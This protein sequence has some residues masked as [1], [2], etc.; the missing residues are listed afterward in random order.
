M[1]YLPTIQLTSQVSMLLSKGALHLQPGQWVAGEKGIG[2]YL[3]TDHRTG[4]TYVSWVRPG[5][6][7]TTQSQRFHRACMKG[8][9]GKYASRYEGLKPARPK[10]RRLR[11][12]SP[13]SH[14]EEEA[15]HSAA[16]L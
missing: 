12:R 13:S 4:T 10:G 16:T 2:R 11:D 1:Q 3:R 14:M 8:Y 7:W 5:D 9:V 15:S 6:D